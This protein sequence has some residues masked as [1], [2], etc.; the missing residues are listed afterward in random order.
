MATETSASR[1]YLLWGDDTVTRAEVVQTFRDRMLA[2]PCGALNL[3]EFRAP[4]VD[5]GAVISACDTAPFLDE[6]RLVIL[7]ELFSWRPPRSR[8]REEARPEPT[9]GLRPRR[10]AFL[11]Y[12]PSLAPTTTLLLVEGALPAGER[13]QIEAAL[14]AGRGDVRAFA[15]PQG[16]AFDRWLARRARQH[17]GELGRGV[18]ASLRELGD[19][20]LEGLDR[21]IA[22]LVTYAADRPVSL[23]DVRELG[24]SAQ[25][26]IFELLDAVAEQR[27]R[28]AL[29]A[30]QRLLGQGQRPE[31][32]FAQL[33]S[34]YRR[35]LICKLAAGERLAPADVQRRFG[36]KIFDKLR[37]QAERHPIEALENRLG[38]V[39][40]M[41][42]R[43]KRGE[44]LPEEAVQLLVLEL[45]A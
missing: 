32:L 30:L 15:A 19:L 17:G 37:R 26:V 39:L 35:L 11:E 4:D 3:T 45:A 33:S 34:L 43:L 10:D 41:D 5:V 14:P 18:A 21:E 27:Q 28:D 40:E 23:E 1:A 13:G 22:K 12:L 29:T 9:S 16:A 31:E 6:R 20:G 2:R 7:H 25:V 36:V 38:C 44:L 8:G 42:R 24:A